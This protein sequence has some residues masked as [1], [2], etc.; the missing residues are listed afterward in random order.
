MTTR[1]WGTRSRRLALVVA[2]AFVAAGPA[3]G[4]P[5]RTSLKSVNALAGYVTNESGARQVFVL[6]VNDHVELS[7]TARAAIDEVV[8]A[9]ATA[10]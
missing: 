7:A 10:R 9:L 3:H 2:L 8:I 6:L 5:T 1:A 4:D